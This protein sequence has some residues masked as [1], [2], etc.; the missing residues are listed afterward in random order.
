MQ[1]ASD[2]CPTAEPRA[3]RESKYDDDE[4]AI[5]RGLAMG[6]GN[7]SRGMR[8]RA[9]G[10]NRGRWS[11]RTRRFDPPRHPAPGPAVV[12]GRRA[13]VAERI[14]RRSRGASDPPDAGA[15]G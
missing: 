3:L 4:L 1:T 7:G 13:V 6:A 11:N 9:A 15:G 8:G 2:S 12:P 10:A 14:V 5:R